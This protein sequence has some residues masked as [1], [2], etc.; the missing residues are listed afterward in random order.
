MVG[1]YKITNLITGDCYVGKSKHVEKRWNE[2][3]CRGYGA[4]H[5]RKFQEAIDQYGIDGFS[6]RLIEECSPESLHKRE[7]YWIAKLH[8]E[9]NSVTVGH[10]VSKE[11]REKIS[12]ALLGRKP[13]P[14]LVE[15]RR[16]AIIA[17]NRAMPQTNAGHRKRVAVQMNVIMEF[18]SV[19]ALA[20]HLDVD[21]STVTKALKRHGTVKGKKVWY[22]V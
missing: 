19:K 7:R 4:R 6:F 5:S 15:K 18:E 16:Q 20:E 21:A 12:K 22:V 14:E 11:T 13:D 1:I 9:Y 10:S 8:P 17:R 3:F 2:H